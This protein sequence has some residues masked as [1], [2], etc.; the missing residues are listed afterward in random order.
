[1][2]I[3]PVTAAVLAVGAF[4]VVRRFLG[5]GKVAQDVVVQKIK[6][7]AKVVDVR[8][9]AEFDRDAF[10]GAI[11]IP[12]PDLSRRIGELTGDVPV[13]VYCATGMRSA[14]AARAI[15]HAGCLDVVNAGGL[16]DMPR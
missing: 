3:D 7:G 14:M 12:L 1:M 13:V 16:R 9:P 8:S 10:P 5:G 6:A 15:R 11:N 4:L 2:S